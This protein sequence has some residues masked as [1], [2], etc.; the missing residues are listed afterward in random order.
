MK[1]FRDTFFCEFCLSLPFRLFLIFVMIILISI[2]VHNC[3]DKNKVIQMK[4]DVLY[5]KPKA[6]I[7]KK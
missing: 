5:I 4:E 7:A 6:D 2:M 3:N 1:K